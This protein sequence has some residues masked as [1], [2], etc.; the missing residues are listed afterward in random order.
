MA[1]KTHN[2]NVSIGA[3]TKRLRKEMAKANGYLSKFKD[4]IAGAGQMIAGAFAVQQLVDFGRE[5]VNLAAQAEGVKT[6]FQKLNDPNLLRQLNVAT[7]GT[8]SDLEL[9]KLAVQ[10]KNFKIPLE[11]LG[12]LLKF[13]NNRA[14]ETGQ[15]VDYLTESIITGIGRKSVLIM[16]NLGISAAELSEE[17]KKVGDF[18]QAAGN[19]IA[20]E[21]EKA[22]NVADTTATKLAQ[23]TKEWEDFKLAVGDGL[24]ATASFLGTYTNGMG[25]ANMLLDKNIE[26]VRLMNTLIDAPK[27]WWFGLKPE[28]T[29]NSAEGLIAGINARLKEL[30]VLKENAFNKTTIAEY[31]IEIRTL[32]EQLEELNNL[33]LGRTMEAGD[34]WGFATASAEITT[35]VGL[36][37]RQMK[38]AAPVVIDYQK[39]L[40]KLGLVAINLGEILQA[41][42]ATGITEMARAIGEAIVGV[43]NFGE[44]VL[45]IV[46]GFLEE[47]GAAFIAAGTSAAIVQSTLATNPYTA[48]AAGA[49]LVAIGAA[50][51]AQVEQSSKG[52]GS[53]GGSFRSSYASSGSNSIAGL[54]NDDPLKLEGEF[55]LRGNDLVAAINKNNTRNGRVGGATITT[56][57]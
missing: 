10:A 18:G 16:D 51:S 45:K 12:T 25:I 7:S 15:S 42:V 49:A 47:L 8:V 34:P 46:G 13:A 36:L 20:R 2:L 41:A 4:S 35:N 14:T 52:F 29:E 56:G 30:N 53:S 24:I 9:M 38:K 3:E 33:G 5:A 43:G 40:E 27:P 57:G 39:N 48:I 50:L 26:K 37:E 32:K 23:M 17:V 22:G 44:K 11:Q 28:D 54:T 6:A 21:M 55:V 31:N 19:I 1:K